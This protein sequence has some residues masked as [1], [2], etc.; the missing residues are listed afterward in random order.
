MISCPYHSF[1]SH[2]SGEERQTGSEKG[3]GTGI[4][5]LV[6]GAQAPALALGLAP[7]QSQH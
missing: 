5:Q 6:A 7:F 4:A 2:A 3:A 1:L